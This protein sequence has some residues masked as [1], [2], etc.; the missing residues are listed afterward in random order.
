MGRK[1]GLH[2]AQSVDEMISDMN[3][4]KE[5]GLATKRGQS[6]YKKETGEYQEDKLR[7]LIASNINDIA[8]FATKERV[9]LEDINE[10]KTRSMIYLKACEETGTFPSSLGLARA[11]GYTDRS[12]R[13]WRNKQ[14]N[15]PTAKWLEMF[16]D[17]CA[18][19]LAQSALKNNANT[20]MSIFLNKAL[21]DFRETSELV[22]TPHVSNEDENN[23]SPEEI[24]KRYLPNDEEDKK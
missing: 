15:T 2:E 19:I 18:D 1:T 21:Y 14:P 5:K 7:A 12:L 3:N 11:L 6:L 4:A 16:N 17:T 24:R 22:L 13:N 8:N 20:I 9:S 10:V 23:Y